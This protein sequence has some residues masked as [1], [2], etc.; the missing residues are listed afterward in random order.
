MRCIFNSSSSK[1]CG[2]ALKQYLALYNIG[3]VPNNWTAWSA[4]EVNAQNSR[5]RVVCSSYC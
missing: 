1:F 5:F 4:F 2:Y 3:K